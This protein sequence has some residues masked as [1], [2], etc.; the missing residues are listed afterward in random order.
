MDLKSVYKRQ[1]DDWTEEETI[2]WITEQSATIQQ[3]SDS[4]DGFTFANKTAM[5]VAYDRYLESQREDR[6][7]DDHLAKHFAEPY[8]RDLSDCFGYN[9]HYLFGRDLGRDGFT[10]WHAAR[11]VLISDK[12]EAWAA[13]VDAPNQVVNMGA[14]MDTRPFWDQTFKGVQMYYEVDTQEVFDLKDTIL[15]PL[16]AVSICQRQQVAMD[17]SKESTKDLANK[18]IDFNV[19]TCWILEGLIMYLA[20][21]D[22]RTLLMELSD[23]SSNGSHLILNVMNAAAHHSQAFCDEI[24]LAKGWERNEVLM[25]GQDGFKYGRYPEGTEPNTV[26]GFCFYTKN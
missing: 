25:F 8:G 11:T 17:F 7:F 16:D 24:L 15:A 12:Y 26:L 20:E 21:E 22:V 13:K 4:G 18:G 23:L 2:K 3:K 19:A 5:F 10:C 1:Y 14:G 9:A 6:L